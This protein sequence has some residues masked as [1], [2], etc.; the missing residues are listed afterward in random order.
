MPNTLKTTTPEKIA[1]QSLDKALTEASS[2]VAELSFDPSFQEHLVSSGVSVDSDNPAEYW[3]AV[4]DFTENYLNDHESLSQV[5]KDS[6]AL[7]A[8]LPLALTN[9]YHLRQYGG[10]MSYRQRRA[11]KEVVCNYN[12]LFKHYVTSYPAQSDQISRH[13]LSAT[14]ETM[15]ADSRD[16][17]DHAER[18]INDRVKGIKHEIGFTKILDTLG[19]DYR[20]TTVD[21][22]L[23]GRDIIIQFMGHE[24]GVDIKASLS[25][26]D[27]KNRGSNGTPIA[28]K[29]NGDLVMFSMLLEPDF[30]GGFIPDQTRI[31][32]IAPAAGA[33]L[34]KALMQSIAK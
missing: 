34:Q 25:E 13:L 6:F 12:D 3:G 2:A 23:K 32:T 24:I 8:N 10:Q 29:T 15:G 30:K 19:V 5:E 1:D 31:E 9:S 21:E 18:E 4:A 28:I 22:D 27:V 7:I 20:G 14:L 33:L 16:F 26:V 11:A 17:T